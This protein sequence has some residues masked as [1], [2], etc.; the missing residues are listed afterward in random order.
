MDQVAVSS[1]PEPPYKKQCMSAAV[2]EQV[3]KMKPSKR[4]LFA[5][6]LLACCILLLGCGGTMACTRATGG[7]QLKESMTNCAIQFF[8]TGMQEHKKGVDIEVVLQWPH[9][10]VKTS[11]DFGPEKAI[12][13]FAVPSTSD[14]GIDATIKA[15]FKADYDHCTYTPLRFSN[16]YA[17]GGTGKCFTITQNCTEG[18]PTSTYGT[19]YVDIW[20]QFGNRQPERLNYFQDIIG[21]EEDC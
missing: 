20:C 6:S 12:A 13:L 8:A 7:R 4:S 1:R 18:D 15:T 21:V 9:D 3:L 10:N 17:A 2:D 5:A 14:S 19:V 11:A 16:I